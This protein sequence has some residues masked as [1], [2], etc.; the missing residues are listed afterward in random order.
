MLEK[1]IN[2]KPCENY[3]FENYPL[4]SCVERQISGITLSGRTVRHRCS[5]FGKISQVLGAKIISEGVW[6]D[7]NA[8]EILGKNF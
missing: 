1:S 5:W 4:K 3:L 7:G 8:S 2:K 6:G